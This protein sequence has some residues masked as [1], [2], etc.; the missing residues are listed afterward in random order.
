MTQDALTHSSPP[1]PIA[2][3]S[4][5]GWPPAARLFWSRIGD[6]A[7]APRDDFAA[8]FWSGRKERCKQASRTL[9]DLLFAAGRGEE[10]LAALMLAADPAELQTFEI[11]LPQLAYAIE[12]LWEWP[13]ARVS[14]P[15]ALQRLGVWWRAAR[16]DFEDDDSSIFWI[17]R[18]EM[19]D[20]DD[21]SNGLPPARGLTESEQ[22]DAPEESGIVVMPA[23][24]ATRLNNFQSEFKD[25]A[26]ARLPLVRARNIGAVRT[27]L[28]AE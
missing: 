14:R 16:G 5:R 6:I 27:Q 7:G 3:L 4:Q 24:K 11:V 18:L 25:L 15:H 20:Q 23:D 17:T 12:H 13:T 8:D 2:L 26:D 9:A 21:P 28:L 1:L 22:D 19:L 10:A